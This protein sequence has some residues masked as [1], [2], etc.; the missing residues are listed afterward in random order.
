MVA[1]RGQYKNRSGQVWPFVIPH[2]HLSQF[3]RMSVYVCP[4][5]LQS[6]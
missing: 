1:R 4:D 6:P 3:A 2:I 5:V